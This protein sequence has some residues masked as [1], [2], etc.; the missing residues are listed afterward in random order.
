[1]CAPA[2]RSSTA[3]AATS[4]TPVSAATVEA[5]KSGPGTTPSSRNV[6]RAASGSAA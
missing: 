6:R 2:S 4:G 1:M 3:A 5:A